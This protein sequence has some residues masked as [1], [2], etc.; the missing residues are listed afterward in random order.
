MIKR[1]GGGR[2]EAF[3]TLINQAE[4][5]AVLTG[6]GMSTESGIPDFRS[7][8]G[9]WTEDTSRMEAMSRE[10]FERRPREFWPKFKQLFQMKMSGSYEPNAGHIYLA[11]LEK[12]GKQVDIFTQNI[13][14]LHKKAGSTSVYELHGSIQTAVCPDCGSRYGI[15]HLLKED[16]P[17]CTAKKADGKVCGTVLKTDVVLFGDLVQHFDTLYEK[18]DQADLLLV[19]GTS[20]EVAPARFVPEDA[21]RIP[22]L[23]QVI[24]NLEPTYCDHLFDLVIHQK[25]GEFAKQITSAT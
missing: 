11:G 24:I 8:D 12:Q 17:E 5:I 6:A 23:K 25:I 4:R 14:G 20:L 21:S 7:A 15:S 22:G 16:V 13:D 18:L 2:V 9:I 1:K 3:L 10:Y 19:I